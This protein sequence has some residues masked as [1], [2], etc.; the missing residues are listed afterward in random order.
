[1]IEEVEEGCIWWD[2][3]TPQEETFFSLL[4]KCDLPAIEEFLATTK[5]NTNIKNFDGDTPL[6][7]AIKSNC[8]PLI[9][10]LVQHKGELIN[11]P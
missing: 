1:M 2:E 3:L 6:K 8:A 7:L 10:L 9:D 11:I 4:E 5:I